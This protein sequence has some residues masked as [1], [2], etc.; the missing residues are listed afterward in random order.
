MASSTA[1]PPPPPHLPF[2]W[3][4]QTLHLRQ[5]G[6]RWREGLTG[7]RVAAGGADLGHDGEVLVRDVDPRLEVLPPPPV[8]KQI[9]GFHGSSSSVSCITHEM[10]IRGW[11]FCP[12]P[13][14]RRAWAPEVNPGPCLRPD[15]GGG[16]GEPRSPGSDTGE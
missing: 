12:P 16:G 9:Q 3:S 1:P 5:R 14:R 6:P 15:F 11:K 2:P 7:L 8:S 4:R 13:R 10:W